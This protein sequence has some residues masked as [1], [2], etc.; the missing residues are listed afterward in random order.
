MRAILQ[1]GYG[2]P[3]QVL[4]LGEVTRPKPDE[5]GVLVRVCA[6][7]VNTPDWAQTLGVPYMLRLA[8]NGFFP[9]KNAVLGDDVSGI[10]E[11]VGTNVT[12]FRPG[13]KVFGSVGK[14]GFSKGTGGTFCEYA[15]TPADSLVKKPDSMSFEEAAGAV[16]SGVTALV[17]VRD[18]AK[19]KPGTNILI[20][21]ASGGVGTFAVQFAKKMGATV[22]GVCSTKNVDLVKS[23]GADHVIDYTQ[24]DYTEGKQKYDVI[25]D[26]VLNHS[27]KE[28]ARVLKPDGFVIP[29]SVGTDRN[30]WFGAIPMFFIKPSNYPVVN[31]DTSRA[32][33]DAVAKM[34]DSG[35]VKVV[36]DKVFSLEDAPEAVAHMA[37]RRARGLVI[38]K[39]SDT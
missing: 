23:L 7:S 28:S 20:N 4:S 8:I 5:N 38:I 1:N 27:F 16:M 33:L 32:N 31:C 3:E 30:K 24:E 17:A 37:S 15:V 21:G 36:I 2:L 18:A 25:L 14:A 11:E 35:D 10:V 26:N 9:P 12:D 6:T 13:D 34:V 19:V 22:T 29:N 39:V